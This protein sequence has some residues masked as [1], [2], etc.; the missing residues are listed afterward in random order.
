MHLKPFCG[1]ES[2]Y[3]LLQLRVCEDC[4]AYSGQEAADHQV[5]H[6]FQTAAQKIS[7]VNGWRE[8]LPDS[9]P[10][11]IRSLTAL[12]RNS[13]TD[14]F[15]ED[16]DD[17]IL[18]TYANTHFNHHTNIVDIIYIK[19]CCWLLFTQFLMA[20]R[21]TKIFVTYEF[22]KEIWHIWAF[23]HKNAGIEDLQKWCHNTQ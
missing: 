9:H 1:F 16:L 7:F 3:W 8:I 4:S 6:I 10:T 19:Y 13:L 12:V 17:L 5:S 22:W 15:F 2:L 14:F 11:Q 21:S 18:Y 20:C 23:W